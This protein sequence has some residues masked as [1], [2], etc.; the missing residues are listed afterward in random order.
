[1][2]GRAWRRWRNVPTKEGG[3]QQ[4]QCVYP[5]GSLLMRWLVHDP[6]SAETLRDIRVHS[7]FCSPG[8]VGA[9][10]TATDAK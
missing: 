6:K 2:C 10:G 7:G 1:M 3:W 4:D 9:V 5:F 8:C